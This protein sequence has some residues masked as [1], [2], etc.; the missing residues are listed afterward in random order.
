MTPN[1]AVLLMTVG[2]AA[3]KPIIAGLVIMALIKYLRK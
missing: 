2:M 1:D 3:V